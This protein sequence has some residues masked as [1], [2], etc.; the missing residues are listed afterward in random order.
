MAA[1][2]TTPIGTPVVIAPGRVML[3]G[4][5][6]LLPGGSAVEAAIGCYARA[7]FIPRMDGGMTLAAEVLEKFHAE[8]G[9]VATALPAGSVLV[10]NED[11]RRAGV[12]RGLGSTAAM[13]V[14]AAGAVFETLGLPLESRKPQVFRIAEAAR[15]A[16]VGDAG[17]GADIAAATYGGLLRI[18]R[19][20]DG[21][22]QVLP[23]APPAGLRL[24]VFSAGPAP[25]PAR[26]VAALD[27]HARQ[28]PLHHH[29]VVRQLRDCAQRFLDEIGSGRATLAVAAAG[30]YGELLQGL[31][32]AAGEPIMTQAFTRAALL[33]RELGGIAKPAGA[34]EGDLGVALFATPEAAQRFRR[35]CSEPLLALDGELDS[36]GVRC[37]VVD[38]VVAADLDESDSVETPAPELDELTMPTIVKDMSDDL[39]V[40]PPLAGDSEEVPARPPTPVVPVIATAAS[41][42]VTVR[43]R[44]AQPAPPPRTP[45]R[46]TLVLVVAVTQILLAAALLAAF[47]R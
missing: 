26:V 15:R 8:L 35:A 42:A 38:G 17:S 16:A 11:F 41:E 4:E 37:Q 1:Q 27:R 7:Q 18:A 14:A 12:T 29:E 24:V 39:I 9:E 34:G 31:C 40:L 32:A 36:A 6:A 25:A 30:K 21:P 44:P 19:P 46:R 23:M 20:I 28:D 45:S 43:D 2:H 33:A 5:Y 13:A 22:A 47:M 10:T 3:V